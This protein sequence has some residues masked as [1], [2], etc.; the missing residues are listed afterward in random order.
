M[1]T[2]YNTHITRDGLIL[3]LDAANIKSYPGS[4]TTGLDLVGKK[5]LT[6]IGTTTFSSDAD[7]CFRFGADGALGYVTAAHSGTINSTWSAWTNLEQSTNSYNMFMGAWPPYFCMYAGQQFFFSCMS[8]GLQRSIAG[9]SNKS[10]NTWYNPTVS[11]R[12]NGTDTIAMLYVNG[13]L[14][15]TATW[16]GAPAYATTITIGEGRTTSWYPFRGKVSQATLYNRELS[17]AEIKNNFEAFR[18]RYGV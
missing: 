6:I 15:T 8:G 10:L 7:G 13:V 17:A 2:T 3:H 16:P 1:T 11:L 18:G 9:I 14:E 12:Y 5:P 4:G